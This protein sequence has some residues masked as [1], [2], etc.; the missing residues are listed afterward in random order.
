MLTERNDH[1]EKKQK[2]V[3]AEL[4]NKAQKNIQ[5]SHVIHTTSD[6][7]N[8]T[9]LKVPEKPV[10]DENRTFFNHENQVNMSTTEELFIPFSTIATTAN[11]AFDE[12]FFELTSTTVLNAIVNINEDDTENEFIYKHD[13]NL[14]LYPETF[15]FSISE[16]LRNGL[17]KMHFEEEIPT[18]LLETYEKVGWSLLKDHACGL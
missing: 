18:G 6:A 14:D 5:K 3:N 9:E 17:G 12:T 4:Q 13:F 11:G 15:D 1:P 16:E 10:P 8:G 2:D 7:S